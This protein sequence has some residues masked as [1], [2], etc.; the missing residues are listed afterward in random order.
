MGRNVA[1]LE[2]NTGQRLFNRSTRQLTLTEAG[3]RFLLEVE[4]HLDGVQAA[5][6][7]TGTQPYDDGVTYDVRGFTGTVGPAVVTPLQSFETTYS[8][9]PGALSLNVMIDWSVVAN[10]LEI[11]LYRPD[12]SQHSTTFLRLDP[13]AGGRRY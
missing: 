10:D 5:I 9:A 6:A 13:A 7:G 12:G 2:R 1:L 11:D 3:E 8:V 4:S